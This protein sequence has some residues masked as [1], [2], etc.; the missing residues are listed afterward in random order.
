MTSYYS[1]IFR[2]LGSE[3]H[4]TPAARCAVENAERRL[5]LQLPASVREWYCNENAIDILARY[6]NNDWPIAIEEFAVTEWRTLRL[7][8]FKNENQGV[9]TWSIS[10]DGS[11]DPPVFVDVD[12]DGANWILQ[13]PTFSAFVHACIWDYVV[14]LNRP[15]LV[16]AQNKPLSAE[17]LERLSARYAKEP[18]TSGWPG[19]TQHRFASDSH[20]ILIW[21]EEHGADW[22]VGARDATSLENALRAIWTFDNVGESL[23]GTSEIG[24][25]VL[26]TIRGKSQS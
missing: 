3:P 8:P 18:P 25:A 13:A 4:V 10:L 20:A 22:F 2:L 26:E 6:S 7:M 19:N 11:D 16:Q 15:V 12:T 21:A 24:K 1:S 14:V 23:Y 9:C 5:G 17:T